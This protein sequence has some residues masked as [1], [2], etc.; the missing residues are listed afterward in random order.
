MTN[1][2]NSKKNINWLKE[3]AYLKG[4]I[5]NRS[6]LMDI[7]SK[8]RK[9]ILKDEVDLSLTSFRNLLVIKLKL[10]I[11]LKILHK[12]KVVK[13]LVPTY[14]DVSPLEIALSLATKKAHLSH[15][16]ALYV[17]GL[18]N[19]T[20]KSIYI[21]EEQTPKKTDTKNSILTQKKIDLA[22][23]RPVRAT[24]NKASFIYK[25]ISY[26]VTILNGK[27][28]NYAG[29]KTYENEMFSKRIRASSAERALIES[30]VRPSYSGGVKQ[31]LD[32][33]ERALNIPISINKLKTLLKKFNYIYPYN[34]AIYFYMIHSYYPQDM[35]DK[36]TT[37]NKISDLKFY[38]D[39]QL[40]N[41]KLDKQAMVYYPDD[42]LK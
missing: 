18:T 40:I 33:F 2:D 42:L 23:S 5:L 9:E 29:V 31:T 32:S 17:N 39:H 1:N 16:S 13:R 30:V 6:S 14:T 41:L 25:N 7:L 27:Y 28:T 36:F 22:F 10:F 38:L 24:T 26:S 15:L 12:D 21:N 19:L 20:P 35:I 4:N 11:E 8:Y 37:I 3:E 34:Q